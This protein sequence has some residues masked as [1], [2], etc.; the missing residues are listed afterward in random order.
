MRIIHAADKCDTRLFPGHCNLISAEWCASA[1]L[2]PGSKQ[3]LRIVL[4][5]REGISVTIGR[6]WWDAMQGERRSHSK[7]IAT[8][9]NAAVRPP[10]AIQLLQLF[11][12]DSLASL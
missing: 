10:D 9:S 7:A 8:T 3:L 2:I 11:M 5:S 6:A 1:P 4:R 12:S